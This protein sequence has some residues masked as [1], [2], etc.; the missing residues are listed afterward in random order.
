MNEETKDQVRTA[1]REQYGKVARTAGASGC[2]PSCCGPGPEASLA[3]GY[4]EEDLAAVP[5][6]AQDRAARIVVLALKD[7]DV[8]VR[9]VARQV[10]SRNAAVRAEFLPGLLKTLLEEKPQEVSLSVY[11]I[12]LWLPKPAAIEQLRKIVKQ[13]A[14]RNRQCAAA[15]LIQAEI[16]EAKGPPNLPIPRCWKFSST[17]SST[18][19]SASEGS[20]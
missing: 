15:I 16:R 2:A 20:C 5:V 8:E 6:K 18:R 10:A 9:K 1:V 4:S 12:A 3:L 11:S 13:G 19:T 7:P 17:A 14:D